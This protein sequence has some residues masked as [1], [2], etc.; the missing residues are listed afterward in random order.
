MASDHPFVS[1]AHEGNPLFEWGLLAV[2]AVAAVVAAVGYTRAATAVLAVTALVCG[3]LRLALRRRS[4]F[5]VRSVAFD[6]FISFGLGIGLA[7]LDVS[8]EFMY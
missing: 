1:E 7:V 8:F 6:A 5:K 3:L 4:P 2:V